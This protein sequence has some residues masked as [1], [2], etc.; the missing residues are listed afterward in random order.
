MPIDPGNWQDIYG[1]QWTTTVDNHTG[2]VNTVHHGGTVAANI[3]GGGGTASININYPYN[4]IPNGGFLST[5]N[6][7]QW[8]VT[9]NWPVLNTPEI[10]D[11]LITKMVTLYKPEDPL[12]ICV[13]DDFTPAQVNEFR[14]ALNACKLKAVVVRGARA[15]TGPAIF[16]PVKPEHERIDILGRLAEIWERKPDLNLTELLAWWDGTNMND[17]D[18]AA[19]TEV[20][21][22]KIYEDHGY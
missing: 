17:D 21:F 22:N 15:G 6:T 1:N 18:F 20:H 16:R 13:D 5:A 3:G 10:I 12:V 19:A 2:S 11:A 14:D 7:I 4:V 8:N 9:P